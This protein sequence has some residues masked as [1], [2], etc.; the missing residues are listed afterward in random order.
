MIR[1]ICLVLLAAGTVALHLFCS[2]APVS[3][4][5]TEQGNPQI[6]AV[7]IDKSKP[8]AGATVSACRLASYTDTLQAPSGATAAAAGYTDAKGRCTFDSLPAGTYSIEAIDPKTGRRACSSG[9]VINE[10]DSGNRTDTLTL[11]LPGTITGVVSRGGV[12]GVVASQ[13]SN[14]RDAA[15]MV[16]I[17]EIEV[18]PRLTAQNGSYS[19]ASLPPGTYTILYYATDGFFSAKRSVTVIA[20]DT[21][22]VDTV[23][24][25]PVPRLLPPKRFKLSY[26]TNSAGNGAYTIVR[27]SWEKLAFD[28]LRFYE[29]ERIDLAGPFDAVFTTGDTVLTDTIRAIPVGTALNYVIRSVDRAFNRSANAGPLEVVVK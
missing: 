22:P 4:P 14:L 16:I 10:S 29:V 25:R 20:G 5:S 9:I 3:G 19:F 11:A 7:V 1:R 24:L 15:I 6:V 8:V 2:P 27:L 21:V 13:N 26:D 17:Q 28:S 12:P 18:A 23:I